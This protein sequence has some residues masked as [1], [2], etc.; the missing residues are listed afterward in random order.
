MPQVQ[1]DL[2]SWIR[3][4]SRTDSRRHRRRLGSG[5]LLARRDPKPAAD[6][7][8]SPSEAT[9]MYESFG[10]RVTGSTVEFRLFL[11]DSAVDPSQYVRGG[12][13]QIRTVRVVGDFQDK[14]GQTP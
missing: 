11:P 10:A 2:G 5:I 9:R 7:P 3:L 12:D 13:P 4:A 6:G 1:P 14:L 8:A